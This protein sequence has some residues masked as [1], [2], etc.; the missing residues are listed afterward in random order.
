MDLRQLVQVLRRRWLT[1]LL[2]MVA[3]LAGTSVYT[4]TRTPQYESSAK[5][6][7]SADVRNASDSFTAQLTITQKVQA[8]ATLATST[9]VMERVIDEL[10]LNLNTAQLAE[11]VSAEVVPETPSLEV[12]TKDPDPSTAQ[13]INRTVSE[14]L[15]EYLTELETLRGSSNSQIN[16]NVTDPADFDPD[17]VSPRTILNLVVAGVLGLLIGIALAVAREILD[18]TVSSLEHVQEV[19]TAPVLASIAFDP[20]IK[21]Q[22]LLTD[23]SGFAARTEA[24]RLLRTNLQFLD[25]D[26]Q[27]RCLVITSAV[28]GEGKSTTAANLAIALS[29]AGRRT[30]IVDGDLR[31]PRVAQMLQLDAAIGLTTVLVGR[32][33]VKEAIQVHEASGLHLLASGAKP[34]NPTEILQSRVTADLI[35]QL[36]D[37]YDMVIIDAPPLLPVADAAVLSAIADG[38]I[39]VTRHA[40]TTREQLRDAVGRLE[41]VGARVSGIVMNMIARRSTNNYYYYYYEE[42]TPNPRRKK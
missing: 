29:Q 13:I 5:V 38:A 3:A 35:H 8:Y 41:Q 26:H 42:T 17:A 9:V 37:L 10:D 28:P 20:A 31:R 4:F 32:A 15:T 12:K 21:K 36:R 40:K 22:P 30:L 6:F 18:R 1:I 7:I 33:D 11:K 24:F 34:P 27:P 25:L 16:A 14:Q 2:I 39:I 19:T 23:V